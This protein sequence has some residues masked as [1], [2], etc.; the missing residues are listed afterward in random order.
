MLEFIQGSPLN[1]YYRRNAIS[2]PELFAL[3]GVSRPAFSAHE[4]GLVHRDVSPDNVLLRG[5]DIAKAVLIDFG[6]AKSGG[7]ETLTENAFAGKLS[8]AAPEQFAGAP[9]TPASDAYSLALLLAACAR[10]KPI[11]MGRTIEEAE[12][13]RAQVPPLEGVP[14][15]LAQ[16]LTRMLQPRPSDRPQGMAEV[17]RLLDEAERGKL[18]VRIRR[19]GV[20]QV[21]REAGPRGAGRAAFALVAASVGALAFALASQLGEGAF[22]SAR[23][24]AAEDPGTVVERLAAFEAR[25]RAATEEAARLERIGAAIVRARGIQRAAEAEAKAVRDGLTAAEMERLKAEQA[26]RLTEEAKALQRLAEADV[27]ALRGRF[28]EAEEAERLRREDKARRVDAVRAIQRQAQLRVEEIREGLGAEAQARRAAETA[29]LTDLARAIQLEAQRRVAEIRAAS[30]VDVQAVAD[31]LAARAQPGFDALDC[32]F[33]RVRPVVFGDTADSIDL[34][35]TGIWG[36]AAGVEAAAERAASELKVAVTPDGR[37]ATAA[38]CAVLDGLKPLFRPSA[39]P[40]LAPLSGATNGDVRGFLVKVQADKGYRYV[41]LFLFNPEKAYPVPS[42]N[43]GADTNDRRRWTPEGSISVFLP[44][45]KELKQ[46][47][48]LLIV[49]VL[50]EKALPAAFLS[51][52]DLMSH[53]AW[54]RRLVQVARNGGVRVEAADLPVE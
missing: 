46:S 8:Y 52:T 17:M 29:R 44:S 50:S 30:A 37:P 16:V 28:A 1:E 49:A 13:R 23:P 10:R 21:P 42:F 32:A 22:V 2:T 38:Q 4:Q 26:A 15:E 6:I 53:A 40:A 33:A 47:S 39:P 43:A 24:G 3:A 14:P 19:D 36:E 27:A 34:S 5:D 45:A 48:P 54:V 41:Y 18:G 31:E 12:R 35:V 11:D 51:Q 9:A 20:A 25:A 7:L